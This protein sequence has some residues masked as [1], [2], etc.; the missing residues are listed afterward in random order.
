MSNQDEFYSPLAAVLQGEMEGTVIDRDEK[1]RFAIIES[2][3]QEAALH[4]L[5]IPFESGQSTEE[6]E[7]SDP[8]RFV[9]LIEYAINTTRDKMNGYPDLA[10]GFTIKIHFGAYETVPHAKLH[11]LSTE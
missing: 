8:E 9:N 7:Q 3:E 4:W 11:I 2:L 10:H 5:A 1:Q 6:L